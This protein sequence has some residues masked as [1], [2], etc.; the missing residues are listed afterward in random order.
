MQNLQ[1]VEMPGAH[2]VSADGIP[3][4]R[5]KE[6]TVGWALESPLQCNINAWSH[7]TAIDRGPSIMR[8]KERHENSLQNLGVTAVEI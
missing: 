5:F 4:S 1:A 2:S 7:L 3:E 8:Q 6:S